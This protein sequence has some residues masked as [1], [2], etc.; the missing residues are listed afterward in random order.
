MK[1]A[2]VA[3]IALI[4]LVG[5]IFIGGTGERTVV[6]DCRIAEISP[7]FP[8]DVKQACRKK[9]YEQIQKSRIHTTT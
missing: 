3:I 4:A 9:L 2:I 8:P 1:E 5:A 7:D 6:Y